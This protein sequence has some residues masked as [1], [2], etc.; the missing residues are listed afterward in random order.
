MQGVPDLIL[1]YEDKWAMLE[2]KRSIK[3]PQQPNQE[4]YINVLNY[5]SYASFIYPENENEVL[6]EI[7]RIFWPGRNP[8]VSIT[9]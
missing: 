9:E 7:Q 5:M 8:R 1:L 3:A 2:V 4:H 6:D